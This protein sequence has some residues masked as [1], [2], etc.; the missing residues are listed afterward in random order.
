MPNRHPTVPGLISD[1][2]GRSHLNRPNVPGEMEWFAPQLANANVKGTTG[3]GS[4]SQSGATWTFTVN[5]GSTSDI[6]DG[7]CYYWDLPNTADA[8]GMRPNRP[9]TF[10]S[11]V[12]VTGTTFS[13]GNVPELYVATGL[14]ETGSGLP[15]E[16]LAMTG[17]HWDHTTHAN[18][19]VRVGIH[20]TGGEGSGSAAQAGVIGYIGMIEVGPN[21]RIMSAQTH[22]CEANTPTWKYTKR[23]SATAIVW[24]SG[25]DPVLFLAVGRIAAGTAAETISFKFHAMVSA[26]PDIWF[27]L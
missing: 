14:T 10:W 22:S 19:D 5:T 26:Q 13:S 9:F 7:I 23:S 25:D 12:E 20:D 18:V 2:W 27:P 17:L 15:S 3:L 16:T 4:V 8:K 1:R 21:R 6:G 11:C 24:D